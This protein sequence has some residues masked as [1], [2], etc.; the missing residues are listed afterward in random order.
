MDDGL[1]VAYI[2]NIVVERI[3]DAGEDSCEEA[4]MQRYNTKALHK[5]PD[6]GWLNYTVEDWDDDP[7]V[8]ENPTCGRVR[9]ANEE[10]YGQGSGL[11]VYCDTCE[12]WYAESLF[13]R[14]LLSQHLRLPAEGPYDIIPGQ[15]GR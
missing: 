9:Y 13:P 14:H 10:D 3:S 7:L 4:R 12:R 6:C 8:C 2:V 5:C 1:T 15:E 11:Y